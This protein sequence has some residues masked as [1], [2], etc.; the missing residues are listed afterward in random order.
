VTWNEI[1]ELVASPRNAYTSSFEDRI[2][3]RRKPYLSDFSEAVEPSKG[4]LFTEK[5]LITIRL[6]DANTKFESPTT[7]KASMEY[8]HSYRAFIDAK[9]FQSVNVI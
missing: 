4:L 1:E 7:E 2:E 3:R 6:Y 8:L 5:K 9:W